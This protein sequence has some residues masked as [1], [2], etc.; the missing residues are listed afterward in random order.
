MPVTFAFWRIFGKPWGGGIGFCH[1]SPH[2]Q[3]D[4]LLPQLR[5]K[6]QPGP[7]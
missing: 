4:L 7:A 6:H 2:P 5:I 3:E 1:F